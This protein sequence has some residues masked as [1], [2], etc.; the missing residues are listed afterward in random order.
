MSVT[1]E[2]V[3]FIQVLAAFGADFNQAMDKM[4]STGNTPIHVAAL[5]GKDN[6]IQFLASRG[7]LH[8]HICLT[9]L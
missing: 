5:A 6:V 3:K 4:Y 1:N 8:P 2:C 9:L 7:P